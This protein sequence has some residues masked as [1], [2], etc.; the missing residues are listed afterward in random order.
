[1]NLPAVPTDAAALAI[2]LGALLVPQAA[3]TLWF[4]ACVR[5]RVRDFRGRAAARN[6]AAEVPAEA[7]HDLRGCDP[8]LDRVLAALAG[9]SHRRWRLQVV[10]DSTD[11]PA[12]PATRGILD[13]LAASGSPSWSGVVVAPLAARGPRGSLK[14]ASLRQALTSLATETSV[15]ALVDADAVVHPDWL[16]TLVDECTRP[17]IGAVSGNRWFDPCDDSIAGVVR[18]EWNAGAV[19]QMTTFGIPWGGSLAVRREAMEAC[20]WLDV[21]ESSLCEDTAL[22]APFAAAGWGYRYVPT[23]TVVD[24]D[25]DVALGP[26]TRWIARQ[27]LTARLHHP[28]WPLVAA[29]GLTTSL[30]LATALAGLVAAAATARHHSLVLIA[31]ALLG[32]EVVNVVMLLAIEAA[33]RSAVAARD[34]RARPLSVARVC[35]WATMI[36]VTQ[37]VYAAATIRALVARSVEWRGVTYEIR[38]VSGRAE[39]AVR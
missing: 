23:L 3:L 4:V 29:H 31:A 12:W 28:L 19:V 1:M 2:L 16:V 6:A 13:R 25:D 14:C 30:A 32:Y 7:E 15:V 18:A 20:G 5:S 37:I 22:A 8:T 35:W 10:V 27:L 38:R 24:E 21:I 36:P 9:Q 33:S 39:V 26:L 34:E 11:D 17:G